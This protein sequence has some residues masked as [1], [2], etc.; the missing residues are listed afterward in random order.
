MNI[1]SDALLY[2]FIIWRWFCNI[3]IV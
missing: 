3:F 1:V 2:I